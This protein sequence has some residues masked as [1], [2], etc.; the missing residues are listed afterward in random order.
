MNDYQVSRSTSNKNNLSHRESVSD[1]NIDHFNMFS[2][3]KTTVLQVTFGKKGELYVTPSSGAASRSPTMSE[4]K[5]IIYYLED[6]NKRQGQE[7]SIVFEEFKRSSVFI[8][9]NISLFSSVDKVKGRNKRRKL[10]SKFL[11]RYLCCHENV[12]TKQCS[13]I[14]ILCPKRS[15]N[16]KHFFID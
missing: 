3:G 6:M 1:T 2:P 14:F 11:N 4:C 13:F 16:L 15:L 5:D 7:V 8:L 12:S 9:F 10:H